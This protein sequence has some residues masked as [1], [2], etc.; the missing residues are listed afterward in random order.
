LENLTR[1]PD[2]IFVIDPSVKGHN[3]A[4]QE[5]K[6]MRIPIAAILDSDDDPDLVNWPIPANDHAKMSIDW[7]INRIIEKLKN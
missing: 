6:R 3:T 5:A 2:I 4:I 7:I 1:L